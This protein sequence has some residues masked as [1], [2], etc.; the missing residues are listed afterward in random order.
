[1]RGGLFDLDGTLA[2]TATAHLRAWQMALEELGV[3]NVRIDL[4]KLL[5]MRAYDIAK[6]V[7]EA[8]GLR[9]LD[10][11]ELIALKTRYFDAIA[12]NLTRPMPCALEIVRSLKMKGMR[13]LVV[14]SSLR[15]S[16]STVLRS[17]GLEPDVL[18]AGDDVSRGKPDPQPVLTALALAS[19]APG[20]V[21]AVGDTLNDLRAYRSAGI[22]RA[23]M[24]RGDVEVPVDETELSA[25]GFTRV[26]TLCEVMGLEGLT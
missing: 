22:G 25:L 26:E 2:S 18:V 9:S 5:G 11:Q 6:E 4:R 21:F 10:L 7:A 17:I 20:E 19:L 8:A 12:P 15:R 16:A 14:T 3:A 23:Y 13:F 24:V 1:M